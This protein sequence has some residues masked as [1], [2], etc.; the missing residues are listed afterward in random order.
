M[1]NNILLIEDD[2]GLAITLKDFF[3]DNG[4][5]VTPALSG[6][7][8]LQSYHKEKPDLIILDII[9]PGKN[10]F[11][12]IAE[13]RSTDIQTPF[14]LMT[15]TEVDQESQIKGYQ[16]GALNYMQKPIIPVALL[17]LVQ[18]ILRVSPDLKRYDLGGTICKVDRQRVYLNDESHQLR[19][20]DAQLLFLLL[21]QRSQIVSRTLLLKQLWGDDHPDLNNQLDGAILRIRRL[22]K[23]YPQIH[24]RSVYGTGYVLEYLPSP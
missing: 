20:K 4:L 16:H 3:E 6:E 9:L 12:V 11:E 2:A 23:N 5:N 10:G 18:N 24:I 15:G 14:I 19:E 17:A 1:R 7:D 13:I 21:D 22:L 8:G